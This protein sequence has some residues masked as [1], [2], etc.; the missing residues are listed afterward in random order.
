MAVVTTG[1]SVD[2]IGLVNVLCE[3]V[4]LEASDPQ[5]GTSSFR[6]DCEQR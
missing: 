6:A 1:D 4:V 3:T 5:L 2:T